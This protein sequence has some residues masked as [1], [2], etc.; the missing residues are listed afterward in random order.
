M[1]IT[2]PPCKHVV[3]NAHDYLVTPVAKMYRCVFCG[4]YAQCVLDKAYLPSYIP[5]K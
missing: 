4:E 5:P 3:V 2:P 1:G